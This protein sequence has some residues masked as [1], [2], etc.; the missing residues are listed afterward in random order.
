METFA[1]LPFPHTE[2]HQCSSTFTSWY[3][4]LKWQKRIKR[5]IRPRVQ[6]WKS[7]T[8]SCEGETPCLSYRWTPSPLRRPSLRRRGNTRDYR[9][10]SFR[11]PTNQPRRKENE[12]RRP[13]STRSSFQEWPFT[14]VKGSKDAASVRA[15]SRIPRKNSSPAER[16]KMAIQ[17]LSHDQPWVHEPFPLFRGGSINAQRIFQVFVVIHVGCA[18]KIFPSA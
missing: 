11:T 18:T 10:T 8:A 5:K 3:L 17:R 7:P 14:N 13:Q 15:K 12:P 6:Q 9:R 4:G 2:P 16:K 1:S